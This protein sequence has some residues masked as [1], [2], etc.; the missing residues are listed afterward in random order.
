MQEANERTV[1]GNFANAS[2]THFVVTSIFFRKDG[3]FVVRT[4]GPDG[5]LR[6]YEIAYTFGVYPLQQYLTARQY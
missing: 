3:K 2:I 4:D 1:L 5:K 6:D